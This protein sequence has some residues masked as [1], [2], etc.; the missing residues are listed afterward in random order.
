[1]DTMKGLKR[2]NYCGETEGVGKTENKR[3]GKPDIYRFKGQNGNC[4][5]C[6]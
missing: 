6:V 5:A 2:T 1:M 4:S 3:F